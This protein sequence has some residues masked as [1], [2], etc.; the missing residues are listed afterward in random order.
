[1]VID[2]E[3]ITSEEL[4][5]L[6]KVLPKKDYRYVII[7]RHHLL[8]YWRIEKVLEK[9]EGEE[10]RNYI[11]WGM[12][13]QGS[14]KRMLDLNSSSINNHMQK[15]ATKKRKMKKLKSINQ[16]PWLHLNLLLR[17]N[18]NNNSNYK[19]NKSKILSHIKRI[20]KN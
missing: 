5:A 6:R 19:L 18:N 10:R 11:V 20:L 13:L 9:V 4:Y 16:R 15:R 1:M 3:T 12:K 14:K 8:G 2:I 7:Y 17:S